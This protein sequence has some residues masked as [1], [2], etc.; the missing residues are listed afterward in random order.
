MGSETSKYFKNENIKTQ[1]ALHGSVTCVFILHYKGIM[2]PYY[3]FHEKTHHGIKVEDAYFH[4]HVSISFEDCSADVERIDY[5]RHELNPDDRFEITSFA[6]KKYTRKVNHIVAYLDRITVKE[7]LLKDDSSIGP[8]LSSFTLAQI[9]EFIQLA[10]ENKCVNVTAI[11]LEHKNR[12]F[13]NLDPLD[14]FVLD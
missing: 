9:S 8:L 2:I 5:H 14:S 10:T 3:H 4:Q 12:H 1:V 13:P 6:F 7:R 11:L